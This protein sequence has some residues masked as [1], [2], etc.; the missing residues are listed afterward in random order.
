[1]V[2]KERKG[3]IGRDRVEGLPDYNYY[4][5]VNGYSVLYVL[6]QRAT[7]CHIHPWDLWGC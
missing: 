5:L 2:R 6:R 7:H 3:G 1:M 4:H